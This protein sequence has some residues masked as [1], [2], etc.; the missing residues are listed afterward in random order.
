M[1][2]LSISPG[3]AELHVFELLQSMSPG[4]IVLLAIGLCCY[5][6]SM[7]AWVPALSR[8]DVSVAYPVLALSYVLVYACAIH[9]PWLHE[10]PSPLKLAGIAIILVGVVLVAASGSAPA[11]HPPSA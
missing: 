10:T 8:I 5:A 4:S 3:H 9:L 2:Q 1:Q 7:I 11:E 6:G